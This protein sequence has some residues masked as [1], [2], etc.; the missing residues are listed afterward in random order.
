MPDFVKRSR[1]SLL[2]LAWLVLMLMPASSPAETSD[3]N[4]TSLRLAVASNFA[5][6][7]EQLI[8]V[9]QRQHPSVVVTPS[10]GSTGKLTSQIQF[11]LAIDVFLAADTAGP[12]HLLENELAKKENV[13][14]Y[15]L[16]R[17][18]LWSPQAAKTI[19]EGSLRDDSVKR[20]ALANPKVA[21]Y[22]RAAE[23]VIESLSL[24]PDVSKKRLFAENVSQALQ[25]GLSGHA[26]LSFIAESQFLFLE[27]GSAWFI[28]SQLYEPIEQQAVL[29]S[30]SASAK[31]F[32][33]FLQSR[34]ARQIISRNGYDL[35]PVN[36]DD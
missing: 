6:I 10:L 31:Q 33:E 26:E 16:G 17:L 25:Y 11:G 12:A 35:P 2:S 27:Q 3:S 34:E 15:A 18:V 5:P 28:P 24:A 7:L 14:S 22:G 32:F 21:P 23:Q 13:V 1:L 8:G 29:I 30:D 20:V 4:Q 36:Q 19:D 9:F